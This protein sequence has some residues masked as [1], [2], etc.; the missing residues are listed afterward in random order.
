L[1]LEPLD[2][3]RARGRFRTI[4]GRALFAV[5]QGGGPGWPLVLVHGFPTSS[6]DWSA[7]LPRLVERRR[8]LALDLLGFGLSEKPYPHEYTIAEQV[9]LLEAWLALEHVERAHILAHD[10]G[11]TVIQELVARR[12]EGRPGVEPTSLLLLNGGIVVEKHRPVLAQKLLRRP[13][14]GKL[15]ARLMG[16]RAF[17]RSL[18]AIASPKKPPSAEEL[19]ALWELASAGKGRRV[20]PA[21]I[22]YLDE[23]VEKRDRWRRA[24]LEHG[25]PLRLVWGDLDPVS[26]FSMAEEVKSRR[27][28]TSVVRLEGTGHYPQVEEPERIAELA[29]EWC[30]AHDPALPGRALK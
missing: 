16:R 3:W 9:D 6:Y 20:Y 10:M 28:A 21:L 29:L 24:T 12:L 8:V 22:R 14:L 19:A 18:R 17:A 4:L 11:D 7:M 13:I 26:P 5:D 1:S 15:A 23:R 25:Y 27:P 2:R 30:A